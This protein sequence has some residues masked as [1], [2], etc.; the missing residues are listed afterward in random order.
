MRVACLL[1]ILRSFMYCRQLTEGWHF[2][3]QTRGDSC[4]TRRS[5]APFATGIAPIRLD[6][7]SLSRLE[8]CGSIR[9]CDCAQSQG[10]GPPERLSAKSPMT[11]SLVV[12]PVKPEIIPQMPK[13]EESPAREGRTRN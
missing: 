9:F 10:T 5:D 2:S 12:L 7:V 11:G 3:G 8:L 13:T 6:G 4:D 1:V